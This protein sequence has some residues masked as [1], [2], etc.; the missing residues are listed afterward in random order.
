M[1]SPSRGFNYETGS[2][3]KS[4]HVPQLMTAWWSNK[5]ILGN[6]KFSGAKHSFWG[7]HSHREMFFPLP[8]WDGTFFSFAWSEQRDSSPLSCDLHEVN[9]WSAPRMGRFRPIYMAPQR[10]GRIYLF[11][12]IAKRGE[13]SKIKSCRVTTTIGRR[14]KVVGRHHRSSQLWLA[15]LLLLLCCR[16]CSRFQSEL[17]SK[18]PSPGQTQANP[19]LHF[20]STIASQSRPFI[21]GPPPGRHIAIDRNSSPIGCRC[22][23]CLF[24]LEVSVVAWLV[25]A[26]SFVCISRCWAAGNAVRNTKICWYIAVRS[27]CPCH[28]PICL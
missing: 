13:G 20:A 24:C 3:R 12:L 5:T 8:L 18:G 22:C 21:R 27:V 7:K 17:W 6:A 15:A 4:S 10:R 23:C 11:D 9:C 19:F 2:G 14:R 1:F 16:C 26:S 28:F 25:K